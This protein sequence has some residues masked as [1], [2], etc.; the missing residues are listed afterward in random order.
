LV[1]YQPIDMLPG[2]FLKVQ[3]YGLHPKGSGTS[4]IYGG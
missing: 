1:H 2:T 3:L 4:E